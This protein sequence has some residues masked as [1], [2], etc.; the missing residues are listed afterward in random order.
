MVKTFTDLKINSDVCNF[1]KTKG[2]IKP[3]SVQEKLIPAVRSG[4][5]AIVQSK[6]GTGKT[7]AFLLPVMERIKKIA[8]TQALIITPTRE[9]AL[10]ISRIA[11]NL[12]KI[13]NVE[14]VII[15][16]GQDFERQKDRLK[17]IPQLIIGTPG[18]LLDHINRKAI[19]LSSVNKIVIDEADE[20]LKL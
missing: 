1:L 2:I 3:T 12:G 18:R 19:D 11:S 9:L 20:L 13:M 7:L 6:T 8:I 15:C 4:K 17:K 14:S 10:Q 16:G 5:D